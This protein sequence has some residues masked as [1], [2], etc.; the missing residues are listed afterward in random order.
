MGN[1]DRKDILYL[2]INKAHKQEGWIELLKY[3]NKKDRLWTAIQRH[4]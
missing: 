3:G 4:L 2:K 1:R